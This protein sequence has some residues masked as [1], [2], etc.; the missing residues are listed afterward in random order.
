MRLD[1]PWGERAAIVLLCLIF[2]LVALWNGFPLMFYDIG[3]YMLQGF[4]KAFVPER[5]QI[6]S[7]FL[8]VAGGRFSMWLV[9]L[10]QCLIVAAAVTEFARVVRPRMSLWT[11]LG[12]G[13]A[14]EVLTSVGWTT[15]E[16]EPDFL[17]PVVPLAL[18]PL[19]FHLRQ[20]GRARTLLLIAIAGFAVAAHPSHLG[21]GA[22][23]VLVIANVKL[24]AH[25][26][27]RKIALPHTNLLAPILGFLLGLF[28]VVSANFFFT[29]GIFVSR[30]GPIFMSARL[31]GDGLAQKTLDE[32]CPTH[33]LRICQYRAR[34]KGSADQFLWAANSPFHQLDRFYGPVDEYSFLVSETYKR[35]APTIL[36]NA[37]HDW[38]QQFFMVRTGDGIIPCQWMLTRGFVRFIP[39]QV[40]SYLDAHQQ[41][42][43]IQFTGLNAVH[44]PVAFASIAWLVL[45]LVVTAWRRQWRRTVL[46]TYI[47]LALLGNALI[48][49]FFSGPHH[50]YQSRIVWIAPLVL[51]LTE[52]GSFIRSLSNRRESS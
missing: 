10:A 45:T 36:G 20:L 25:L 31:I 13:V 14:L 11:L 26:L 37:L 8:E 6:Y 27:R 1:R 34:I 4:E 30:A 24:A 3:G 35:Y 32:I 17:T 48:C 50:R 47:L 51:L 28:M 38:R 5:A 49:G 33:P 29:G 41:D 7:L 21:L 39:S 18:Y 9:A 16:I 23:L 2:L 44:L 12:I 19:A 22:G 42:G 40:Q 15:G 43:G 46:P 52:R